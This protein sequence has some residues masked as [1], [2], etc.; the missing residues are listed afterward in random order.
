MRPRHARVLAAIDRNF[1][2]ADDALLKLTAYAHLNAAEIEHAGMMFFVLARQALFNDMIA[3]AIR[4]F[5]DH[6]EAGSLWYIIRCHEAAV[7]GVAQDCGVDLE[8]L[9]AMVPKLRHIR[10][11][12]HFHIDRRTL[13]DPS[14]VW[15]QA[16][17]SL[18]EFTRA[19]HNVATLLASLKQTVYQGKRNAL[20]C[21][22]GADVKL[23]VAAALNAM[24]PVVMECRS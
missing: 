7:Q 15:R 19:L 9:K 17:I 24:E 4:I 11:K 16:G 10:D 22:D 18:E 6:K 14:S 2:E 8:E 5:D 23:I 3:G 1:A 12:T 13:E 21:Y 20:T